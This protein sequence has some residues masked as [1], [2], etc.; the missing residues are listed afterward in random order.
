MESGYCGAMRHDPRCRGI[1]E[2]GHHICYKSHIP[3]LCHW[4]LENGI[5]LSNVC[6]TLA[7]DTHNANIP[8]HRRR[9]ASMKIRAEIARLYPDKP[10]LLLHVPPFEEAA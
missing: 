1:G 4:V 6:H 2:H 7:H 9:L 8:P 10:E 3:K 5:W